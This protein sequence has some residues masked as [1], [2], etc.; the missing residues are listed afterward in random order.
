MLIKC[1]IVLEGT[2]KGLDAHFS[3]AELLEPLRRQ[4]VLQQFSPE[5]WFRKAKPAPDWESLAESIPRG[6][7]NLLEQLQSGDFAVRIKH[8][9]LETSV[10]RM[11]TACAPRLAARL[12]PAVDP[13]GS[14]DNPRSIH[15]GCRGLRG[16]CLSRDP[17]FVVHPPLGKTQG[18]LSPTPH[19]ALVATDTAG[20]PE[21]LALA[22]SLALRTFARSLGRYG[23]ASCSDWH[24]GESIPTIRA[25][26]GADHQKP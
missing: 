1:L 3:L 13:R 22:R 20:A 16:R 23:C 9:P 6:V 2:A 11:D 19:N 17:G 14:A 4:F 5:T 25:M 15:P 18:R 8:P 7:N 26:S 10:N 21:R 24:D 12:G